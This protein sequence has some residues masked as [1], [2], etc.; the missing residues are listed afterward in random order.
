M[1]IKKGRASM[2]LF[3][4]ILS[5]SFKEKSIFRFDYI[6]GSISAFFYIVLKVYLWKGL[7]GA[8]GESIG[9][10]ALNSMITYS[11]IA[12]LT[13]GVTKTSVM[14]ELNNSVLDGTISADLLLPMG[15]KKY[16]FTRSLARGIFHTVYGMAPSVAAAILVFGFHIS[17][18]P[19]NLLLYL[20]SVGMGNVINFLYSFLFGSSVIWLRNS[21]FLGNINSVLFSL[22]SGAFVPIWFFPKGLKALSEFLPFRYIV[23]EPAAIFVN[24]KSFEEAAEVL[25]MQFFWIVLLFGAATL[26][27]NRGRHKLMIQGG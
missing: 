7:Y 12:G 21:F 14:K 2:R 26:V 3:R 13:E 6:V 17:I 15:L 5:I 23:F 18:R 25:R 22:F 16:M 9:G 8:G 24:A 1:Q 27:W 11:I 4:K 20:C 19:G 10:I